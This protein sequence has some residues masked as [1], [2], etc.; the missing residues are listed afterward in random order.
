MSL[1]RSAAMLLDWHGV[2]SDRADL[3]EAAAAIESSVTAVV[4]DPA[5]RTP[6]LGGSLTTDEIAAAISQAVSA[7]DAPHR[8]THREDHHA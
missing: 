4:A 5:T 2:R 3:V 7:A 8:T 6:D 1:I